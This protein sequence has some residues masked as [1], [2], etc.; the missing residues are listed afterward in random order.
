MSLKYIKIFA[1]VLLILSIS[2]ILFLPLHSSNYINFCYGHVQN[3]ND[4]V[5]DFCILC[6]CLKK[7]NGV[8]FYSAASDA[9]HFSPDD[10][11]FE[12]R[13]IFASSLD[14]LSDLLSQKT[15]MNN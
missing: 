14:G 15:R 12:T 13:L 9:A 10:L 11:F 7:P 4:N 8:K 5:D 3:I 2:A 1:C 6:D